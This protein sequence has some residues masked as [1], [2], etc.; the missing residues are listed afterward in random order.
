LHYFVNIPSSSVPKKT[1]SPSEVFAFRLPNED[2]EWLESTAK[3]NGVE[4]AQIVRWAVL[5]IKQ[6]IDAHGGRIH[7]PLD[8]RTMWEQ[9]QQSS[10]AE[11]PASAEN[12]ASNPPTAAMYIPAPRKR[13]VG[14]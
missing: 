12:A 9:R 11:G 13:V 1:S 7:L 6:Y 10:A 4:V 8:I 14:K 2:R 5:A 3:A